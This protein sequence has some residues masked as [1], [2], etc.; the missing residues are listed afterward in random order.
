MVFNRQD[1]IASANKSPTQRMIDEISSL[2]L[3]SQRSS[4]SGVLNSTAKQ[5]LLSGTSG[6]GIESALVSQTS[7][8]RSNT[9]ELYFA[10]AGLEISRTNGRN[11]RDIRR[12]L[13]QSADEYFK[14]SNPTTRISRKRKDQNIE[15]LSA[16]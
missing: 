2:S 3:S 10:L 9:E 14:Q 16:I 4:I 12:N 11:I 1:F 8:L 6:S 5:L 7:G 15:I 13:N